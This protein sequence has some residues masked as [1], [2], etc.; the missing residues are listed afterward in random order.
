MHY[1]YKIVNVLSNKVYIGQTNDP[2]YRWS[3]HKSCAKNEP[4]QYIH[5]AMAKH[6]IENFT[7]QIIDVAL[8]HW[9]ADCL[10]EN[11]IKQCGSL[12][13]ENGYNLRPGGRTS[14]HSDETKQ[15]LREATLKQIAIQGHPAQGT[16]RTPEQIENLIQA[17][18]DYPVEYTEE[19]R[20]NMSE[21]HIGLKDTEETK[22]RKS[23]SSQKSWDKRNAERFA[24]EDI[25]CHAP[26]C[27]VAGKAKYKIVEGVRYC[28]K[29]GQRMLNNGIL[30]KLPAFKWSE[31]H[32]MPEEVKR[33]IREAHIGKV[34]PNRIIF[35]DEQIS[36]ILSDKCSNRKIAKD[37]GVTEKVIKRVKSGKY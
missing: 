1:I 7:F 23:E 22:R 9:Q 19:I 31:E 11:Y 5:H 15:K 25:R 3:Q 10:E 6:G 35:T 4:E 34:A 33:K 37:F 36:R 13:T 18:K 26:G 12:S 24:T 2:K 14:P 28:N 8:N 27:E 16:K 32:P 20:K 21:A 17:R 29:H 30:E